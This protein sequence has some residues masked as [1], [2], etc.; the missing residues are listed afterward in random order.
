MAAQPVERQ[1]VGRQSA[2]RQTTEP[3]PVLLRPEPVASADPLLIS[4]R[5][6][7][8]LVRRTAPVSA[9]DAAEPVRRLFDDGVLAALR[10]EPGRID[11]RLAA[12]RTPAADGPAVRSALF[13]V[14]SAPGGWPGEDADDDRAGTAAVIA[15]ADREIEAAVAAVLAG[16]FGAYTSSHGGAVTLVGV[17]DGRV[18]VRLA[19]RCHGCAF[20]D[21]TIRNDLSARLSSVP[22]FR[23]VVVRAE[24]DCDPGTGAPVTK[25]TRARLSLPR[26]RRNLERNGG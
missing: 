3:R 17:H 19:G 18:H 11:T 6:G 25:S 2:D 22:G 10:V 23:E 9:Q 24:V 16:D 20:A 14:L 4:W 1:P 15:A 8:G 13:E 12:G 21:N 7:P 5:V 26:L